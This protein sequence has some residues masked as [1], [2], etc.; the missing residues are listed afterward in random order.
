MRDFC[1]SDT[2]LGL[3]GQIGKGVVQVLEDLFAGEVATTPYREAA[4]V[5]GVGWGKSFLASVVLAYLAHRTLCLHDPQAYYGLAPGSKIAM[6]LFAETYNQAHDVV[7]SEV[8]ARIE[9]SPWFQEPDRRPDP[10]VRSVL[11]FPNGVHI[12]PL[13]GKPGRARGFNVLSAV[14]DEASWLPV[15]ARSQRMAGQTVAGVYDAAEELYNAV[16]D[17]MLSRGN[18]RWKRDALLVMISSPRIQADFLEQKITDSESNPLIYGTRQATW[19]GYQAGELSGETFDDAQIGAVPVEYQERFIRD[20]VRARRDLGAVPSM[21]VSG[22][23]PPGLAR[24][25]A[26]MERKAPYHMMGPQ[27]WEGQWTGDQRESFEF[28]RSI[29]QRWREDFRGDPGH[30][31]AMH[32]DLATKQ[33]RCGIAMG[34][35]D[36]SRLVVDLMVAIEAKDHGG[37][38][39]FARVRA[40]ILELV[41]K[42]SFNVQLITFDGWQSVD[43]RQIL[44][45]HGLR[46][47][48]LS[49][50]KKMD[51]Y[52]TLLELMTTRR[53]D[54]WPDELFMTEVEHLEFVQGK[55]I[56]HGPRHGKDLSDAVAGIAMTLTPLLRPGDTASTGVATTA[57]VQG[58][59]EPTVSLHDVIEHAAVHPTDAMLTKRFDV[60]PGGIT[61]EPADL[62][63]GDGRTEPEKPKQ[64]GKLGSSDS[65]W[66]KP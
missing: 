12:I 37:Q 7:F 17:R 53:I 18:E 55:K 29:E 15:V 14:I 58:D 3:E 42:L 19:E 11:R 45:R 54:Y 57:S 62:G 64:G 21:A 13:G 52:A 20:P 23:F 65:P 6:A 47:D 30:V 27:F 49:V 48:L 38:I 61:E 8:G 43:S 60:K 46:A 10:Q 26:N 50:D 41:Q 28:A 39:E 25:A 4:L 32:V 35:P 31:Y 16:V 51:A 2:Y 33:D 56:D 40:L 9:H 5:C 66:V 63:I 24:A 59:G 1:L 36:A 22:Y 44:R 34:H